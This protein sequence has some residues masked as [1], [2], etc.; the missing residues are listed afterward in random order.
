MR[1][2][3]LSE[4]GWTRRQLLGRAAAAAA[5]TFI[6]MARGLPAAWA[7]NCVVGIN[8]DSRWGSNNCTKKVRFS[9]CNSKP[10][11]SVKWGTISPPGCEGEGDHVVRSICGNL[12][13]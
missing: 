7:P 10:N 2:Y 1:P 8:C 12:L 3:L 13:L 6:F 9:T 5:G 4:E 11:R